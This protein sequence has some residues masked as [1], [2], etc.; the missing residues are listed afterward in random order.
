MSPGMYSGEF[1][2]LS[3]FPFYYY[4]H[5]L[6]FC[7]HCMHPRLSIISVIL[8]LLL[9][10]SLLL[11]LITTCYYL[12]HTRES[13]IEGFYILHTYLI[14]IYLCG[15]MRCFTN[16]NPYM[17]FCHGKR[18]GEYNFAPCISFYSCISTILHI[19]IIPFS[20]IKSVSKKRN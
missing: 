1:T 9:S 12:L 8:L 13:Y 6:S 19:I 17:N 15:C 10:T 7:C 2:P 4:Y 16:T 5:L 14:S 20:Q 3:F 11:L 18:K